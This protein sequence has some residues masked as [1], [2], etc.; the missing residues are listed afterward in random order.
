MEKDPF[1]LNNLAEEPAHQKVLAE[2]Q[3]ILENWIGRTGDV[4]KFEDPAALAE[5]ERLFNEVKRARR[6]N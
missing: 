2:F 5:M 3:A 4:G 6:K 1:E